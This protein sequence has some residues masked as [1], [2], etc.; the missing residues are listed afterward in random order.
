MLPCAPGASSQIVQQGP[1]RLWEPGPRAAHLCLLLG[2]GRGASAAGN[3]RKEIL[4]P[5][6]EC[7]FAV[8][9]LQDP[10]ES[11]PNTSETFKKINHS[12]PALIYS[13]RFG[14]RWGGDFPEMSQV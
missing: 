13:P 10:G 2:A 9:T 12:H 5:M 14:Q 1:E 8:T 4:G 6:A 3:K 7:R 11:T